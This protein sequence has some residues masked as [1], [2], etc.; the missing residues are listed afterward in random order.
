MSDDCIGMLSQLDGQTD[1]LLHGDYDQQRMKDDTM[2][3][4]NNIITQVKDSCRSSSI[5]PPARFHP[6]EKKGNAH[7]SH[8]HVPVLS[9]GQCKSKT[10]PPLLSSF[11]KTEGNKSPSL[12][13]NIKHDAA[14]RH[15]RLIP[16]IQEKSIWKYMIVPR[17]KLSDVSE[18]RRSLHSKSSSRR[19][20]ICAFSSP[21][22]PQKRSKVS[23]FHHL[24]RMA[25]CLV[26]VHRFSGGIQSEMG[27]NCACRIEVSIRKRTTLVRPK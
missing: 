10:K 26:S 12:K 9:N 4:I 22:K 13:P 23:R 27:E 24:S 15:H 2:R 1:L 8:S 21:N 25:T 20:Q 17:P 11:L 19:P 7:R 3:A 18:P 6:G 5:V 16:L 14:I